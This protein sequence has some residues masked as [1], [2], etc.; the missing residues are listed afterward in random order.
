MLASVTGYSSLPDW[1]MTCLTDVATTTL[2]TLADTEL[3]H[4]FMA[5]AGRNLLLADA[6]YLQ[7]YDMQFKHTRL[8]ILGGSY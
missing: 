1:S 6:Y 2:F 3:P 8:A 7:E 4:G 5:L